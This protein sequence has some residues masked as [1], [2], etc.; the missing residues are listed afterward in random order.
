[1]PCWGS[2]LLQIAY[3][4]RGGKSHELDSPVILTDF[5][6]SIDLG[7]GYMGMTIKTG[8]QNTKAD[9]GTVNLGLA[10]GKPTAG[11]TVGRTMTTQ[12]ATEYQD[13]A[14]RA[15]AYYMWY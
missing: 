8:A 5:T 12:H 15:P 1:M 4:H 9:T 13:E 6:V 7:H 11:V 10:G 14:V 3:S 2:L